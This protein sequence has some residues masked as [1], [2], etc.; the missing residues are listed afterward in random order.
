VLLQ[1][2]Q[3]GPHKDLQ[4]LY[5][6]HVIRRRSHFTEVPRKIYLQKSLKYMTWCRASDANLG[7]NV[8]QKNLPNNMN[9]SGRLVSLSCILCTKAT[10]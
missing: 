1:V 6:R 10:K 5:C 3:V 8:F 7:W 9:P 4:C 2:A